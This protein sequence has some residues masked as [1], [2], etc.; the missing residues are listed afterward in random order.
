VVVNQTAKAPKAR[1]APRTVEPGQPAEANAL[2]VAA[3]PNAEPS[4]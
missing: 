1:A 3:A 2:V 4:E